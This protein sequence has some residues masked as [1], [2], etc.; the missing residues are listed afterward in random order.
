ME[1]A[2]YEV[3]HNLMCTNDPEAD[4]DEFLSKFDGVV[5]KLLE[6]RLFGRNFRT[7]SRNSSN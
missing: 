6:I 1:C 3:V 7:Q 4:C 5:A 2:A